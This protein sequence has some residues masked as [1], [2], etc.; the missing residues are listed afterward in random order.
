VQTFSRDLNLKLVDSLPDH[1]VLRW[2]VFGLTHGHL[3]VNVRRIQRGRD[4]QD[5]VRGRKLGT[6][7]GLYRDGVRDLGRTHLRDGRV[8]VESNS[9]R[10]THWW[11]RQSSSST[12]PSIAALLDAAE[13][14]ADLPPRSITSLSFNPNLHSGVPDR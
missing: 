9:V 4:T 8:R 3:A 5:D 1:D 11:K 13:A 14:A 10:R 2:D 7:R 12:A 6:E